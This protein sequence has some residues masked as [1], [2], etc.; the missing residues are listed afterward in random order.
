MFKKNDVVSYRPSDNWCRHGLAVI[1]NTG[2]D[3]WGYA[4]DTYWGVADRG[5]YGWLCEHDLKEAKLIGNLDEF[6][7]DKYQE[8]KDYREEDHFWIPMGGGS[9]QNWYR[10]GA[11]PDPNL[12]CVRLVYQVEKSQNEIEY[13]ARKR[14]WSIK[15]LNEHIAEYGIPVSGKEGTNE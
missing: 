15:E 14:D 9:E 10:K 12:V 8:P 11:K 6:E 2:D 13:A 7:P 1:L 5:D 3:G 4:K